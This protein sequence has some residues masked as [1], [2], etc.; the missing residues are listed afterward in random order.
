MIAPIR[1]KRY[2][3][4]HQPRP[5]RLPPAWAVTAAMPPKEMIQAICES[6]HGRRATAAVV[7]AAGPSAPEG[8]GVAAVAYHG[9]DEG[10]QQDRVAGQA[11]RAES[12]GGGVPS[13]ARARCV[14]RIPPRPAAVQWRKIR[15]SAGESRRQNA[16]GRRPRARALRGVPL[17]GQ[18][19][20][21]RPAPSY[22]A[23]G[24]QHPR[25]GHAPLHA[26]AAG[27]VLARCAWAAFNRGP[28]AACAHV[29]PSSAAPAGSG[30][31]SPSARRTRPRSL[32]ALC[33]CCT[34][35]RVLAWRPAVLGGFPAASRASNG[36]RMCPAFC[37]P[38]LP[39]RSARSVGRP[40]ALA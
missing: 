7:S 37:S 31:P 11:R 40:G 2:H 27:G 16:A 22:G 4:V 17:R 13:C 33:R 1:K 19:T 23:P 39:K 21:L 14:R 36:I 9:Q 24:A 26:A 32:P 15:V 8:G 34:W 12:H 10:A 25:A 28:L 29:P 20:P 5:T 35:G 30:G 18:R 6:A 3:C 38:A